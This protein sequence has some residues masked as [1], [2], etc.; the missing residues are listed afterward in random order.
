MPGG[1]ELVNW[2]KEGIVAA[3]RGR[4]QQPA[5]QEIDVT[6][7]GLTIGALARMSDVAQH[8]GVRQDYPAIAQALEKSASPQLRNMA[9]M[10]G[11]LLQR[12]R[13]PY[14]RAEADLPCNKRRPGGCAARDGE[15][16][17]MAVFGWSDRCLA[18]HPSDVAVALVALEARL[19]LDGPQGSRMVPLSEFYLL[20]GETPDRDTVLEP[21]ELITRIHVPFAPV[22]RRSHYLKVRE[23]A[24]TS[25]PS[26]RP[27]SR[28]ISIAPSSV[29]GVSR[30]AAWHQNR[31]AWSGRVGAARH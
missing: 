16:R 30:S 21:G 22:A 2:L 20:P 26:C 18:T 13:C 4:H 25:S 10:G 5:G 6:P 3:A 14:F 28:S 11:N 15:D 1:T 24:S 19:M 8:D 17:A 7:S 23:R 12:T 27:R 29:Q 31:G 9:S